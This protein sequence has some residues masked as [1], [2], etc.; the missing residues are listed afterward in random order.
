MDYLPNAILQL[1][2]DAGSILLLLSSR[3]SASIIPLKSSVQSGAKKYTRYTVSFYKPSQAIT[4]LPMDWRLKNS[5]RLNKVRKIFRSYSHVW[6][7]TY[8]SA[9]AAILQP[10][11]SPYCRRLQFFFAFPQPD[12]RYSP[13]WKHC[14]NRAMLHKQRNERKKAAMRLTRDERTR[15]LR[16]YTR[17]RTFDLRGLDGIPW[18][19][20]V[21]PCIHP[22]RASSRPVTPAHITTPHSMWNF[23][24]FNRALRVTN[25]GSCLRKIYFRRKSWGF[26]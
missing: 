25:D 19:R 1:A 7:V 18:M 24:R 9:A 12:R 13:T 17:P 20:N 22:P 21:I 5:G 6:E 16:A 2:W 11:L 10:P 8:T 14:P 4:T 26:I 15:L 23:A 3:V